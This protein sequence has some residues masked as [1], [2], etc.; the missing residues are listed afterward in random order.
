M[1]ESQSH[2]SLE[3]SEVIPGLIQRK[4]SET[5]PEKYLNEISEYIPTRIGVGIP[6]EGIAEKK[7]RGRSLGRNLLINRFR[8]P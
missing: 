5:I 8:N 2:S 4:I 7:K 1:N 3:F 6:G